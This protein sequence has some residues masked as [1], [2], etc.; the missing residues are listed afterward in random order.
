MSS[1]FRSKA[2]SIMPLLSVQSMPPT[3]TL[4]PTRTRLLIFLSRALTTHR[5]SVPVLVLRD[6]LGLVPKS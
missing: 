4:S 6:S 5:S 1:D 2:S 3:N